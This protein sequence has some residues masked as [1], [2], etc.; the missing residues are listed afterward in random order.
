MWVQLFQLFQE[1]ERYAYSKFSHFG[2]NGGR[3]SK[4]MWV[5]N[6]IAGVS[7]HFQF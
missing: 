6:W 5:D 3:I 7:M 2:G 4:Y 1:S